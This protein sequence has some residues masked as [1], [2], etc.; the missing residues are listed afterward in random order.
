MA[1]QLT[2]SKSGKIVQVVY[3]AEIPQCFAA[4]SEAFPN[5]ERPIIAIEG[6]IV[7]GVT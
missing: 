2:R 7:K 4:N 6:A 5:S 3:P 1:C